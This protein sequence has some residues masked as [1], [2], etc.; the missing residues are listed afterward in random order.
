[1]P[2]LPVP[3]MMDLPGLILLGSTYRYS[4]SLEK[5]GGVH[6]QIRKRFWH[7]FL[8]KL[9][10]SSQ[11]Y[12]ALTHYEAG[13]REAVEVCYT[14]ATE[15]SAAKDLSEVDVPAGKYACFHFDGPRH[16]YVNFAQK[17]YMYVLPKY[18]FFRREGQDIECFHI[19][20]NAQ[21]EAPPYLKCDYLIPIVEHGWDHAP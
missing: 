1:M 14:I 5:V 17:I 3:Q 18:G 20:N 7:D 12:Y 21:S 2:Q 6:M 15:N 13:E 16:E 10:P 8:Q 11:V 19:E 4:C 9:T